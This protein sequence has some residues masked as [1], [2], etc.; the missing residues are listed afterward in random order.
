MGRAKDLVEDPDVASRRPARIAPRN[1]ATCSERADVPAAS[2]M[3]STRSR[4]I[5]ARSDSPVQ[6]LDAVKERVQVALVVEL[7]EIRVVAV[8]RVDAEHGLP[9]A[10]PLRASPLRDG[11]ED[12]G[13]ARFSRAWTA[14]SRA[15]KNAVEPTRDCEPAVDR[16]SP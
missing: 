8:V 15:T 3:A 14:P 6:T 2:N 13:S 11:L 9:S 4:M 5:R 10:V 16:R 12:A 7:G 1:A